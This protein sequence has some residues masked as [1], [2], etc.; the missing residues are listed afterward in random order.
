MLALHGN[1]LITNRKSGVAVPLFIPRLDECLSVKIC[2]HTVMQKCV[3]FYVG[4]IFLFLRPENA[5]AV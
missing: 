5:V 3:K 1:A 2:V 4:F